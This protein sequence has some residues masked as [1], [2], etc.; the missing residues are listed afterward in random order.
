[1]RICK[2]IEEQINTLKMLNLT[3]VSIQLDEML[4][5]E[6]IEECK[7]FVTT[8]VDKPSI[9]LKVS[10]FMGLEIEK[11]KMAKTTLNR[12]KTKLANGFISPIQ[13]LIKEY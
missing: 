10:Y 1:M 11:I 5:D 4:Y 8:S 9:T 12:D 2:A 13:I 7:Q 3:P 6:F